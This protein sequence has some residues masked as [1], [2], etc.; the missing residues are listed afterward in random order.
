MPSIYA[1]WGTAGLGFHAVDLR[2]RG[3][4]TGMTAEE[5]AHV[6]EELLTSFNSHDPQRLVLLLSDTF[7]AVSQEGPRGPYGWK[8]RTADHFQSFPDSI[9]S[10]VRLSADEEQFVL[11]VLWTGTQ[12]R[13]PTNRPVRI[14]LTLT[15]KVRQGKLDTLR[16]DYDP[17]LLQTQLGPGTPAEL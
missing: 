6:A 13:P 16:I 3:W 2:V 1:Y 5:N 10:K 17:N 7:L 15:G 9:F 4:T 11:E 14:P 12:L 8:A